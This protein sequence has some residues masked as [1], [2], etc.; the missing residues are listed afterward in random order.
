MAGAFHM[1]PRQSA[2]ANCWAVSSHTLAF[3]HRVVVGQVRLSPRNLYI[4]E[5]VAPRKGV[6]D[7]DI[8]VWNHSCAEWVVYF[9]YSLRLMCFPDFHRIGSL[10]RAEAVA[11]ARYS[12]HFVCSAARYPSLAICKL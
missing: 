4:G 10:G 1:E 7:L 8:C 9:V 6:N 11:I 5:Y 3:I 2:K 12:T